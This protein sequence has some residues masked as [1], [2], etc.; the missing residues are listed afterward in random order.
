MTCKSVNTSNL[1][2]IDIASSDILHYSERQGKDEQQNDVDDRSFFPVDGT[3]GPNTGYLLSRIICPITV[4]LH[5]LNEIAFLI[6][7]R[8]QSVF[9]NTY[10]NHFAT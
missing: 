3:N 10:S 2:L 5:I 7:T 4:A 6:T 8:D 1:A 9:F